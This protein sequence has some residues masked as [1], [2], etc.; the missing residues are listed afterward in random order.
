MKWN[1]N[2][3]YTLTHTLVDSLAQRKRVSPTIGCAYST[4][5]D[6]GTV[7]IEVLL[8]S[9]ISSAFMVTDRR[10]WMC[11][12]SIGGEMHFLPLFCCFSSSMEFNEQWHIV[13]T[14]FEFHFVAFN[15]SK[16][17]NRHLRP[18]RVCYAPQNGMER[19]MLEER[20]EI[21]KLLSRQMK[22]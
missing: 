12:N 4:I 1:T 3:Q 7:L 15:A 5:D 16:Y 9:K 20:K 11:W 6:N 2:S 19:E 14:H 18:M 22:D 17:N 21:S 13:N 10:A 8:V